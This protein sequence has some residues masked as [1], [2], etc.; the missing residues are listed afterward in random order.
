MAL[1]IIKYCPGTLT[2]TE[3]S[4]SRTALK[5][6]FDGRKVNHVLPY[7]PPQLSEEAAAV[8]IENRKRISI[9]GVQEKLSLILDKNRLRLT[10]DGE[11]GTH[12]LKPIPRDLK[13]VQQVPANEHLTMQIADQVYGIPTAENGL[14]F[15]QNG[16]PA[17]LTRRFDVHPDGGKWRVEDFASL[18]GKTSANAGDNFKYNYSYEELGKLLQQYVPA[19]RIEVEKYFKLVLFNY[20]FSNGDAHLKNFSLIETTSGDFIL[21]PAYDLINTH[22]HV[23][24]S[25]FALSKGL[26]EDDFKSEDYNKSNY[27]SQ[28][29]FT[30]FANRLGIGAKRIPKLLQ[31]FIEKQA[32]VETLIERSYLDEDVKRGYWLAYLTRRNLLVG[33]VFIGN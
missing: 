22:I 7:E 33:N 12:L 23:D 29:D 16:D 3:G 26:F 27:P 21:S 31:P 11:Q 25:V 28:Q 6:L 32:L 1:P 13:K 20:L 2:P 19:Y 15:F 8:F 24:D 5:R 10:E 9:S 18:A 17:Y 14:I 4:Y 30:E